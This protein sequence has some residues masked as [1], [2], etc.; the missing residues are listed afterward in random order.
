MPFYDLHLNERRIYL[1][2]CPST[3]TA[4]HTH[5]FLELA[6]V[7]NGTA[8]HT[9]DGHTTTLKKGD[10]FFIDFHSSHEYHSAPGES[11]TLINCLF[12]PEFLDST[13]KNCPS[14]NAMINNYRLQIDEKFLSVNPSAQIFHDSD[15]E[16]YKILSNML[17]EYNKEQPG[18]L[19]VI[20]SE[21]IRLIILTMRKIYIDNTKKSEN[22]SIC[23]FITGYVG[24]NYMNSITL[25][26]I[27]QKMNY[28]LPYIS[29]KFKKD[30]NMTFTQY[31]QT[32]RIEHSRRLLANTS[33][34]I[35]DIAQ[36]VGYSD[37]KTFYSL[38]KRYTGYSPLRFRKG[39][40]HK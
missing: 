20:R 17:D 4:M 27:C 16:I 11:F 18:F 23:R 28:S 5:S 2:L 36:S 6:Y 14:F 8:R 13:L 3:A 37:T 21:L 32:V 1:F 35:S 38:F 30:F 34:S 24:K 33:M 29:S 15:A 31:L 19:E 10:Y 12:Y 9:R 7:V 39:F 40:N 25:S 22:E 26:E